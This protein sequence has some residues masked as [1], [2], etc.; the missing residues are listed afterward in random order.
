MNW[1]IRYGPGRI[2]ALGFKALIVGAAAGVPDE[3]PVMLDLG[4]HPDFLPDIPA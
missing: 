3:S 4:V 1:G 2:R